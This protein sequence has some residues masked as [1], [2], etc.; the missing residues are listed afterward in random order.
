MMEMVR[1]R[2]VHD[3]VDPRTRAFIGNPKERGKEISNSTWRTALTLAAKCMENG[4]W[5]NIPSR[6]FLAAYAILHER[7]YGFAPEELTPKERYIAAA[8]VGRM[9]FNNFDEDAKEMAEFLRWTWMRESD[10]E[11]WRRENQRS[12]QRIGWRLQFHPHL[13]SDYRADK[14]RRGHG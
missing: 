2:E 7:V 1:R 8:A 3:Q 6:V 11:K 13:L 9:L 12:G 5:E 10:R 14:M 4:K